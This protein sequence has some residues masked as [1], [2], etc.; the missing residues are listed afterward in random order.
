[1]RIL[2][3]GG[4]L[5]GL[6]TAA[7][8]E[9]D[10]HDVI[11]VEKFD[12]W[13]DPVGFIINI[14][15]RAL[16]ILEEIGVYDDVMEHTYRVPFVQIASP[17]GTIL[18]RNLWSQL[19]P[20]H[21]V[22]HTIERQYL[23][24]A[25]RKRCSTIKTHLGTTSK[26]VISHDK[27]VQVLLENGEVEDVDLVI[28]C[29]GIHSSIRSYVTTENEP[30]YYGWKQWLLW[31]PKE[32]EIPKGATQIWSSQGVFFT[33]PGKHRSAAWCTVPAPAH[34][35]D[36]VEG[37][38]ERLKERFANIGWMAPDIFDAIE[39]EK[40]I[41]YGDVSTV[42]MT[43]WTKG[44]IVLA[45]DAQH[46]PTP[47]MGIGATMAM[48]DGLVLRDMLREVSDENLEDVLMEY[49]KN[50]QK[51]IKQAQ[52]I[53]KTLWNLVNLEHPVLANV[54]NTI[55]PYAAAPLISK[56]YKTIFDE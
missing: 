20:E 53:S 51:R 48:E 26:E 31:V 16:N 5:C 55:V 23:H 28:G 11:L 44:R 33:L 42:E 50:R 32:V 37:R 12:T 13:N 7:L 39:D 34:R 14:W 9:Q 47:L 43:S 10:G 41:F 18:S 25:L 54:R 8:L 15:K 21:E 29:D 4:G 2:I 35:D 22:L 36:P 45:G 27:G 38:L 1:M 46:A 17:D 52:Q 40:D 49:Q 3:Q 56:S 30:G 19:L 6:T 24:E